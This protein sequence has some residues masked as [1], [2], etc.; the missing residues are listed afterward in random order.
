MSIEV[1]YIFPALQI[2]YRPLKLICT[3]KQLQFSGQK[4]T[5]IHFFTEKNRVKREKKVDAYCKNSIDCNLFLS[6][7][8]LMVIQ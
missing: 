5:T 6:P 4:Q 3:Q 2:L 7:A 1:N 8:H